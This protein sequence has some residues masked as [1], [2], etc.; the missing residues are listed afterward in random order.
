MMDEFYDNPSEEILPGL[1]EVPEAELESE[2][3][4]DF[5]TLFIP[6]DDIGKIEIVHSECPLPSAIESMRRLNQAA[7]EEEEDDD[8]IDMDDID[9]DMDGESEQLAAVIIDENGANVLAFGGDE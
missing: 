6:S 4:I 1:P 9:V 7:M 2:L 5:N 8:G 3:E